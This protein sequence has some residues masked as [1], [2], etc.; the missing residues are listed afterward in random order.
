M[1]MSDGTTVTNN[2]RTFYYKGRHVAAAW[3]V[4]IDGYDGWWV[5]AGAHT[6][7]LRI[8][9]K[10]APLT[11]YAYD[12]ITSADGKYQYVLH[13]G[14]A[15]ITGCFT[16]STKL[17]IPTTV[18]GYS[19][20]GLLGLGD[21]SSVVKTLTI[22][23]NITYLGQRG[24]M[25][26]DQ[27]T[28]TLDKLSI[29]KNVQDLNYAIMS[30]CKASEIAVSSSNPYLSV[31]SGVVYNK[32]K[33]RLLYYPWEKTGTYT[34][35][36]SVTDI[37]R[38]VSILYS[39]KNF[40][41][42]LGT[43]VKDY[44]M[45]S[46]ALMNPDKTIIYFYNRT[47]TGKYT[48]PSTV[49]EFG[50]GAF[51]NAAV[52]E[53]VLPEGM[54]Y[55]GDSAFWGCKSLTK[56][57]LPESMLAIGATAFY[58]CTALTTVNLPEGLLSIG[59]GAFGNT[60]LTSVKLP[61]S[62]VEL[63]QMAFSDCTALTSVTFGSGLKE[64]SGSAF[65]RTGLKTVTVPAT[66][67]AIGDSAF[68]NCESL[69]T[70][71]L[72]D[73]ITH[74][75]RNAFAGT[76]WEKKQPST[77]AIYMG[78]ILLSY[79]GTM[80]K[81]TRFVIKEGTTLVAG[82]AFSGQYGLEELVI[83]ASLQHM[84]ERALYRCV[85]IRRVIIAPQNQVFRIVGPRL[86]ENGEM[87]WGGANGH[88][89]VN[90][91]AHI[92]FGGTLDLSNAYTFV[93]TADNY[94]WYIEGKWLSV[95]GLDPYAS[96]YQEVTIAYGM[97][98]I[99]GYVYVE[100][101]QPKSFWIEKAPSITTY[102]RGESLK[103]GDM[104]AMAESEDGRIYQVSNYTVSGYDANQVGSQTLTITYGSFTQ[105]ITIT[106]DG[107]VTNYKTET[108]Q[109]NAPAEVMDPAAEL[110]VET[111]DIVENTPG[112]LLENSSLIYDL[113]F[114]KDGQKLQPNG[115]VQVFLPI[116]QEM[117]GQDCVVYYLDENGNLTD[118]EAVCVGEFMV[119]ET[120][121]FS[122]YALVEVGGLPGD[123]DG[124]EEKNTEDAVYLL[125]HVLFGENQY[126]VGSKTK[127]DINSDGKV[128]TEDAVYLLLNVLFGDKNYPLNA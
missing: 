5:P 79:K 95:Y 45:V 120:D 8:M 42:K 21:D 66:V 49:R 122:Y 32:N 119:F 20:V 17:T 33:T 10:E 75:G 36:N 3:D 109:I 125:L 93:E 22:G 26:S 51:Q 115:K 59:N 106:V 91:S 103:L 76:A 80:P 62:L 101:V 88:M 58:N 64:I 99:K 107:T 118:M 34:V 126:P 39:K 31:S 117:K 25:G 68:Y 38:L 70:I 53:V 104:V 123:I 86:Y 9:G 7:T 98:S 105:T 6:G 127:L 74:V 57:T 19:V 2:G 77:G 29:G 78:S 52:T 72:P 124:N 56:V 47:A 84:G 13:E 69:A 11:V 108:V 30:Y 4:E 116:P 92:P 50:D 85:G 82:E 27:M 73:T 89:T 113:S 63:E 65:Y 71:N 61:D 41:L 15:Y 81:N 46:N 28:F 96:G 43:G 23:D 12:K 24:L 90:V 67:T 87:I 44:V 121:H 114:E 40:S 100:S 18:D 60:G 110:V 111:C 48:V 37:D 102:A 14:Q 128:D 54:T 97:A 112:L 1:T 83:P 55:L 16:G 35:P 94:S